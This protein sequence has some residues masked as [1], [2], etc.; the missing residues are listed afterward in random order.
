MP[1]I[2]QINA[3]HVSKNLSWTLIA[4]AIKAGHHKKSDYWRYVFKS[5]RRYLAQ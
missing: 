3:E 5:R 1:N 2:P 4:N